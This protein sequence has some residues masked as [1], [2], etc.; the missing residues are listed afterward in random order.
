MRPSIPFSWE[1]SE[2][3]HVHRTA[4]SITIIINFLFCVNFVKGAMSVITDLT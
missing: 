3:P 1:N 4:A 2:V